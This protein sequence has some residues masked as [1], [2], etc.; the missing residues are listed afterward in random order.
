MISNKPVQQIEL[1]DIKLL[2]ESQIPEGKRIEFKRDH[3]SRKDEGRREFARDVTAMANAMGGDIVIGIE[4]EQGTASNILG[5]PCD[6]FDSLKLAIAETLRASIE[7]E[8]YG[9]E[10][11]WLEFSPRK[12]VILIRVPKSWNAPHAVIIGNNATFSVRDENGKHPMSVDEIPRAFSGAALIEERVR[13]FGEERRALLLNDQG[14]LSVNRSEPFL[15][16]HV[17]PL[18]SLT[19]NTK[20]LNL[21]RGDALAPI[22]SSGGNFL[23]SIDGIVC[24][25][26]QEENPKDPRAFT[27]LFRNGIVEGV[28]KLVSGTSEGIKLISLDRVEMDVI[29]ACQRAIK[30]L[31]AGGISPPFY[32]MLSIF[33]A[34]GHACHF[35]HMARFTPYVC[36]LDHIR[37]PELLLQASDLS[38]DMATLL[39]PIFD[40]L[41]N[42][43]GQPCSPNYNGSGNYQLR[44]R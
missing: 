28:C 10:I 39:R 2:V 24:Y 26:G 17:V 29:G 27:T 31:H 18:E 35:D 32:I 36:R 43:F 40:V 8:L 15:L 30:K 37:V 4:E 5:V 34:K 25:S 19:D 33:G 42:A 20:K 12:G 9:V 13:K 1:S 7:P 11:R 16:L 38:I 21:E 44:P 6:D 14:P 22:G 3:Y 23:F 41:W